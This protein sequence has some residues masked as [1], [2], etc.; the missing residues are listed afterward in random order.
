M[1]SVYHNFLRYCELRQRKRINAKYITTSHWLLVSLMELLI[2]EAKY[3][4]VKL[5]K[6]SLKQQQFF[7]TH[8]YTVLHETKKNLKDPLLTHI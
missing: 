4:A 8:R 5:Y 6:I 7:I 1:C 3:S 2:F